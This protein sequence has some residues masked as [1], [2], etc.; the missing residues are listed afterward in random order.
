MSH[1]LYKSA[2]EY[3]ESTERIDALS[4]GLRRFAPNPTYIELS[5]LSVYSVA[6]LILKTY[7]AAMALS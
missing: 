4:V 6:L 5:V 3:T 7:N 1:C 2:T